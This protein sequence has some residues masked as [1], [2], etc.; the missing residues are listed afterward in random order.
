MQFSFV[1]IHMFELTAYHSAFATLAPTERVIESV[2]CAD[3]FLIREQYFPQVCN[4]CFVSWYE[5]KLQYQYLH[6]LV[7]QHVTSWQAWQ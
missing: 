6:L 5:G 3:M 7:H 4:R 1:M 2:G